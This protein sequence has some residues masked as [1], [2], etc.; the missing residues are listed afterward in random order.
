[1]YRA[2]LSLCISLAALYLLL[3][4]AL[5][6]F[7]RSLIYFPQPRYLS[8]PQSVSVLSTPDAKLAI[9]TRPVPG[10]NAVLY[11]GGNAEDVSLSLPA[12]ARIFPGHSLYLL[13]YRGYGGSTGKPSEP[14]LHQDALALYDKV[15][16]D[17]SRITVIGRSLGS[18]VAIRLA[19]ERELERLILVTPYYSIEEIA[20]RQFSLFPV[21]WLLKDK[22]ESWRDAPHVT[23][24]TSIIAAQHDEVIPQMDTRRLL[25]Q[26]QNGVA[27]FLIIP[28]S[29][30]NS[31]SEKSAYEAAL[32]N[33]QFK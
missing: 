10:S 21:R 9:T 19:T 27:S 31:I 32:R 25:A 5:F 8:S 4:A 7:Q 1:M 14:A 24:P 12:L 28:D 11:F 29:N 16:Q 6:F 18:G 2:F 22:F 17:H 30:H 20:A 13:H 15:S 26:F 23:V 3:C 33:R